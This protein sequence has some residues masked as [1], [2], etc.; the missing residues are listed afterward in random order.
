MNERTRDFKGIWIPKELYLEESLNWTE[1]ILLIEI[2]SLDNEEGCYASNKYFADFLSKSEVYISNCISKLKKE[3]YIYQESFDGRKRV[4]K[5]NM[6]VKLKNKSDL[7]NSLRQ[8]KEKVKGGQSARDTEDKGGK[9][10]KNG[11]NKLF[12]NIDYKTEEEERAREKISNKFQQV[13]DKKLSLELYNEMLKFYSDFKII[14]RALD[15][16]EKNG[17]KPSYLLK[18]LRDWAEHGLTSISSINTY[19]EQRKAER[20]HREPNKG[21]GVNN[22]PPDLK[23][24][25]KKGYQ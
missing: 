15:Y 9:G 1:K 22:N 20:G 23:D 14:M 13:F 5:S 8:D 7:N 11:S 24:L 4:L 21:K 6:R 17:D 25:Y 10:K 16:A 19:L 12:N 18:L 3:G 2:D